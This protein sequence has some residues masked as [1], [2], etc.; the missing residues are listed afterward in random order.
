MTRHFT[1]ELARAFDKFDAVFLPDHPSDE[2]RALEIARHRERYRELHYAFLSACADEAREI[3]FQ[4]RCVEADLIA[5][6][7][8]AVE[9]L[10]EIAAET[11]EREKRFEMIR[12]QM[13][14]A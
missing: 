8:D 12:S 2:R 3:A 9:A 11:R 4:L 1:L 5:L 13:E 6:R 10:E 14:R 7:L